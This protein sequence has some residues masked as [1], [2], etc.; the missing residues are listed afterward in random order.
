MK[1]KDGEVFYIGKAKKLRERWRSYVSGSDTRAFVALLDTLLWD[2]EVVLTSSE[3][4]AVILE[5]ELIKKHLPRFNIKLIDDKNF[6]S[7]R[8]DH[9]KTYPRLELVRRMGKDKS[10]YFGPY[11]SASAIR[12]TLRLVN[13][14]FQLRTCSDQVMRNRKRP[15][16]QFQIKRCPAPCVLDTRDEYKEHIAHVTDFLEGRHEKLLQ[17]LETRMQSYSSALAFEQAAR[18]RDQIQAVERSMERQQVVSSDFANRDVLGL[19]RE[20]PEIEIHVMRTRKGRL[21]EGRRFSFSNLEQPVD[22]I[23]ADFT[24]RYYTES[25]EEKPSEILMPRAMQWA[26]AIGALLSEQAP[27]KVVLRVPQRGAKRRLVELADRNAEQA[28]IDKQRQSAAT[29]QAEKRLQSRLKLRRLPQ[30]IECVDIS[31]LQGS[32]IVGSVVRFSGGLADKSLYRHYNIR[33]TLTQ[34]DFQSIYEVMS[35]RARRGLEAADMPDLI[36][37]DGGK[38]QLAAARAAFDDHGIEDQVDLIGLAKARSPDG[39]K[40]A[41]GSFGRSDERVFV[42]GHKNPIVLRQ[43]SAELFLLTR[44]RDE[45][46]RFAITFHRQ[47]RRKTARSSVLDAVPGIGPKRRKDLLRS[48][49]SIQMLK[50]AEVHEIAKIVGDKVAQ[51]VHT[52]LQESKIEPAPGPQNIITADDA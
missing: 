49:G 50:K 36:V 45:A 31:H 13:R 26:A 3:K 21:V 51:H 41:E 47:K 29:A 38:G 20:G 8:L 10:R 16:L 32:E 12:R 6:L 34:D 35:R 52:A 40:A 4:E 23:L 2:V 18:V 28:F 44:A 17:E 11:H 19:Y 46:H 1:G 39:T 7:L 43:N 33:S 15:C 25:T 48:F 30:S 27:H 22:E 42:T 5:N 9:R 37:I 14:Y 24:V